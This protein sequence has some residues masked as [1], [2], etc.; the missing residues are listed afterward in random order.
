VGSLYVGNV[1][2]VMDEFGRP[3]R[4]SPLPAEAANRCRIEIRTTTTGIVYAPGTNGAS[5]PYNP[6]LATNS[7]G[8]MG[9]NAEVADSGLFCL[10]FADRP[11]TAPGSSRGSTM[12]RRRRK[13]RST[14]IPRWRR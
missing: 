6:L 5:S 14:S 13:R 8:G 12:R 7:V 9:E 2:P 4:G 11:A 10:S 1:V 3:M